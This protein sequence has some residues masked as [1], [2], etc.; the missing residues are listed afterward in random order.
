[1]Q[2]FSAE[3][4]KD[5]REVLS[6][7]VGKGLILI[8]G[9]EEAPR[10][11][12]DNI[13]TFRQDSN[14]LY[15]AGH[16]KPGL[17]LLIDVEA[18]K[19]YLC[20]KEPDM[21][22]IIWSGSMLSL[23]EM[24][25]MV[26]IDGFLP[27]QDLPTFIGK[28]APDTIHFL[29]PYRGD[30]QIRLANLLEMD[31]REIPSHASELLIQSVVSQRSIKEAQ[32]V[33][34]I[35]EALAITAK[36]HLEV[37]YECRPGLYEYDLM[38][39]LMKVATEQ[40][41]E[42]AYPAILTIAGQTLHNHRHDK[43]LKTGQLLL[44]DFGAESPMHYAA[45]IT[46]TIPVA[47]SFTQQQREIYDL[48]NEMLNHAV[49]AL[50]PEVCYREVHLSS[51]LILTKGL[52]E[53][54]LMS[55]DPEEAVHAGAHALFFPHGLGHMLGLDVHDMEDL[56]EDWVGY[57]SQIRRSDQFGLRSLRLGKALQ[58]GFV[59]TVEPGI[60]FIPEL[61][62]LWNS[63]NRLSQFI[64]YNRLDP[65]LNFGGIRIED[66]YLITDKSARLLGEPIPKTADEVMF[67]RSV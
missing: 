34:Q 37:M 57:D 10:N 53:L 63:E 28:Y 42:L 60:Y 12:R 46:R 4:Y 50:K 61:I 43:E 20:G 55:G 51:A 13:Y 3:T 48:V 8:M 30:R 22:D 65:Y 67:L 45:D 41:V 59:F 19:S 31:P 36:M 2:L 56:G 18:G 52:K 58:P 5:R 32:E 17:S 40:N 27:I 39:H 64:N 25:E 14:F 33:E 54:G 29:P 16:T 62:N 7:N 9:N 47:R 44:G 38:G 15:Y 21:D 24:A 23:R 26:G 1:M 35:E 11:Y 49:Q 66:N 6:Q